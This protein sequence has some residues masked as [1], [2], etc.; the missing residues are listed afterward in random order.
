MGVQKT[1]ITQVY[2][3]WKDA[4]TELK[5]H[6]VCSYHKASAELIRNFVVI[7]DNKAPRVDLMLDKRAKEHLER[8]REVLRS[9]LGCL[10]FCGRQGIA[11]RG[12]W[13]DDTST[14]PQET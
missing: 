13:D 8:H 3:N 5:R 14:R 9:I 7:M 10:E 2:S 4:T 11:L 12:H 1:L 6:A